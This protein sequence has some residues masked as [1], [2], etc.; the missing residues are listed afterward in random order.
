MV[1]GKLE[2]GRA[3]AREWIM[4]LGPIVG[5]LLAVL[6]AT[7]AARPVWRQLRIQT[8]RELIEELRL[9][10]KEHE[11]YKQAL[12]VVERFDF[13]RRRVVD[14][15]IKVKIGDYAPTMTV[16]QVRTATEEIKAVSHEIAER[17]IDD[18]I[19][20]GQ[21]FGARDG[22]LDA[23]NDLREFV[24]SDGAELVA[25]AFVGPKLNGKH[26]TPQ[27]TA[28]IEEGLKQ[29][30]ESAREACNHYI[31]AIVENAKGI[32]REIEK[33]SNGLFEA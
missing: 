31:A 13:P 32:R 1:D 19:E 30:V 5:A 27:E 33:V 15:L 23:L 16:D 29:R 3:C 14:A 7:L 22:L 21:L 6:A 2:D 24:D 28:A 25:A 10:Y 8:R 12:A 17:Q 4:S 18:T 11:K 26:P 9:T 20:I